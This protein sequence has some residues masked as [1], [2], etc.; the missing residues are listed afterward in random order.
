M[1]YTSIKQERFFNANRKAL[2]AK[3]VNVAEWNASSKGRKLPMK[4]PK[5]KKMAKGGMPGYDDGGTPME[6]SML[7]DV[8]K[9]ALDAVTDPDMKASLYQQFVGDIQKTK[10]IDGL[11]E[12]APAMDL[13]T[14]TSGDATTRSSGVSNA[15]I[16]AAAG[17]ASKI[18]TQNPTDVTSV[19]ASG[20]LKGVSEGAA[21]GPWGMAAGALL[22][23]TS[24]VI[25]AN[26]LADNLKKKNNA[27]AQANALA[28]SDKP[29]YTGTALRTGGTPKAIRVEAGRWLYNDDLDGLKKGGKPKASPLLAAPTGMND[30]GSVEGAGTAK[31]DSIPAKIDSTGFI[32]PAENASA[33]ELLR[34]MYLGGSPTKKAKLKDGGVGKTPVK[35]SDGEHYFTGA[36]TALLTSKGIDLNKLAPNSKSENKLAAGGSPDKTNFINDLFASLGIT[37]TEA[38]TKAVKIWMAAEGSKAANNPLATTWKK[39]QSTDFNKAKVQNYKSYED[40]VSAI[41]K[42]IKKNHPQILDSLQN[43]KDANEILDTVGKSKWGTQSTSIESAK[44]ATEV[45]DYA[46]QLKAHGVPDDKI[47]TFKKVAYDH[48]NYGTGSAESGFG[49]QAGSKDKT[50]QQIIKER[51]DAFI[52]SWGKE[53]PADKQNFKSLEDQGYT[54]A[55]A[56]EMRNRTETAADEDQSTGVQVKTPGTQFTYPAPDDKFRVTPK[57]VGNVTEPTVSADKIIADPARFNRSPFR[58]DSTVDKG[59]N[60]GTVLAAAQTGLGVAN[61]VG[62]GKRPVDKIDP[63]LLNSEQQAIQEANY[64][65]TPAENA[66]VSADLELTRRTTA[67]QELAASGGDQASAFSG[68]TEGQ[69]VKNRGIIDLGIAN[70]REMQRKKIYANS[71]ITDVANKKR[72]LFEDNMNAFN[73]NQ[74]ASADLMNSGLSNLFGS[75]KQDKFNDALLTIK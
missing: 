45:S 8:Q 34:S 12:A 59:V 65:L 1:P 62:A 67:A 9:S 55:Q 10:P 44:K 36:E 27:T 11:K 15:G 16:G 18:I 63:D 13:K 70:Q 42:T 49:T 17:M 73:Q 40:G 37:P 2:E 23:G 6:L 22:E 33:A 47:T 48:P 19:G 14:S 39:I 51:A 71:L 35:L 57:A 66:K 29:N 3:G 61:L 52:Q 20:V 26:K 46:D 30:G 74:G 54:D 24:A 43:G 50:P 68:L 28:N 21:F 31:S 4:A 53:I 7:S 75:I 32:V 41:A 64:G 38:N 25:G 5:I 69:Q 72:Q 58:N 56:K 60:A